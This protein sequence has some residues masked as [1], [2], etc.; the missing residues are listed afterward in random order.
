MVNKDN[1]NNSY[2]GEDELDV[3]ELV[4]SAYYYGCVEC[5]S[6]L[7]IVHINGS[8]KPKGEEVV[9]YRGECNWNHPCGVSVFLDGVLGA[10]PIQA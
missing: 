9:F 4:A 1:I 3:G 10:L 2:Y 5:N 7:D 6:D 8:D